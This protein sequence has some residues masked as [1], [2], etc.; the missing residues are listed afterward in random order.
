M[1]A[2]L[3]LCERLASSFRRRFSLRRKDAKD[4]KGG[5]PA[6]APLYS[7]R[8]SAGSVRIEAFRLKPG[9]QTEK[10][11]RDGNA[12]HSAAKLIYLPA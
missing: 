4:A 5:P 11:R 1:A 3:R 10:P 12:R 9:P 2:P 8:S 7:Q 6:M